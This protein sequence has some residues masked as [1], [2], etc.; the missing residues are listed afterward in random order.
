MCIPRG[1][2]VGLGL[3][4]GPGKKITFENFVPARGQILGGGPSRLQRILSLGRKNAMGGEGE[5]WHLLL[6]RSHQDSRMHLKE[7]N[8]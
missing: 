1:G 3:R 2:G 8:K 7:R 6:S 4:R 5:K